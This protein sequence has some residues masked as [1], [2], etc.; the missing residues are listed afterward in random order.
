[1][2]TTAKET[3][4]RDGRLFRCTPIAAVR[5]GSCVEIEHYEF[6][7]SEPIN[8][9]LGDNERV[10]GVNHIGAGLRQVWVERL[11]R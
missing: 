9:A 8:L 4:W 7:Y 3:V 11:V 1:M 2:A 10:I 5:L 6:H